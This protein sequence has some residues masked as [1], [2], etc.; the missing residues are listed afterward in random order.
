MRGPSGSITGVAAGMDKPDDTARGGGGSR[1]KGQTS[2]ATSSD[3]S[4]DDENH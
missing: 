3:L 2:V 1:T 4:T